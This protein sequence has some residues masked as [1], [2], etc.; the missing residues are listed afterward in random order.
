MK[1]G[2]VWCLT[3]P[4]EQRQDEAK[5]IRERYSDRIPC[6]VERAN[7]S[8]LADIDKKKF[9]VPG[10]LTVAQFTYVVRKRIKLMPEQVR[11]LDQSAG[12]S[13]RSIYHTQ[14][15]WIFVETTKANGKRTEIFPPA[16]YAALVSGRMRLLTL[17]SRSSLANIYQ[18]YH[19]ED[20]FIYFTYK[21]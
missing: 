1:N 5:K 19:D 12:R 14:A 15:L 21:G 10:D 16:T 2:R 17:F 6:I 11:V 13:P 7:G 18:Q 9:L 3:L 20:Y 8:K 4:A